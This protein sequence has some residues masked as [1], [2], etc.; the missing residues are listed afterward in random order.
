MTPLEGAL[1]L[2][3]EGLPVFPC[4]RD[5]KPIT[6]RGCKDAT[7]NLDIIAGWWMRFPDA[8][9]GVPTGSPSR[10]LVLDVDPDGHAWYA[11]NFE[12]LNA[13]RIHRTQRGWHLLYRMPDVPIPNSV[14]RL[15]RGIDVRGEGGYVIWWPAHGFEAV[16]DLYDIGPVPDGLLKALKQRHTPRPDDGRSTHDWLAIV[17]A[18]APEGCRNDTLAALCGYLL[19]KDIAAAVV[20]ELCIAW[21]QTRCH[22]AMDMVEVGKTLES[23]ARRELERRRS[24]S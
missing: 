14:G 3:E 13:G 5:K 23:I 21:S 16:G 10:L 1:A 9:V 20:K 17:R 11:R 19:G 6:E 18:G 24:A 15:A 12:R 7:T 2:A 8:L 4:R 22:P